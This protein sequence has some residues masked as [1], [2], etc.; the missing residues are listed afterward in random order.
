V[1]HKNNSGIQII[2]LLIRPGGLQV[3]VLPQELL[4]ILA[5]F[6]V[7]ILRSLSTGRLYTGYSEN[8]LTRVSQ[9]NNKVSIYT[10]NRGPW[11]LLH[12]E[13]FSTRSQAMKREKYLK[14]G[15][16]R[17]EIKTILASKS[18]GC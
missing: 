12:C 2:R 6:Y 13:E 10:K 11:Q 17:E 16:G 18:S 5:M 3:R 14:T 7:Y 1:K 15:H 9:H 8:Y 4:S